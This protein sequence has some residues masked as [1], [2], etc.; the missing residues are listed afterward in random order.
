MVINSQCLTDKKEL[1]IPGQTTTVD[2]LAGSHIRYALTTNPTIYVSFIEQFWQ[3]TT[4]ETVNDGEQQITVTVDG[5]TIAITEASV[6]RHLQLADADGISSLP[7]TEIFEQLTLMGPKKTSWEQF[8]SN[9]ATAII[10]LATNRTFKFSKLIFDGM[11]KNVDSKTKFL[12]YP[13][14]IQMLL[15]KKK[16]LL[17]Q[18]KKTYV[19]PSLTQKL[20]SNMKRGFSGEHIPLFDSML[21][22]DQPGQGE[23]PTLTV[24]SQ[25]TPIASP[26]TSQPTTSQPMSSQEQPSQ[27]PT[28]EPINTT[29]SPPLYETSIPYT[30]SSMPHDSPLSGGDTPGS[31]EGSKKLNELTELCTKLF[32]KVTS[33]EKDLKQTKKVYGKALTKLVKKV[34]YLEDKLKSTTERR[35]ERMV[36]SDDEE[37]LVSE[38]PYKQGR[39]TETEY[40]D[41]D[42]E[43]C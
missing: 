10:C 36:I 24:E 30:T 32:D 19:A 34:K 11:V 4:V 7:N 29:S 18:H 9:I 33:L 22:H 8:S 20:F 16:R 31:D 17:K 15:N 5:Q 27:V 25:H 6:R 41:V 23:G 39:M 13:R 43:T 35:K 14:F 12:M 37:D 3:T 38:D 26:T 2:F 1:A 28:T 40:E 42:V 21:I